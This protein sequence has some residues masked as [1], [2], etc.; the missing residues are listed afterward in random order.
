[1][2]WDDGQVVC[3]DDWCQRLDDSDGSYTGKLCLVRWFGPGWP[4][5]WPGRGVWRRDKLTLCLLLSA[6]PKS[7]GAGRVDC[8]SCFF[9]NPFSGGTRGP[10]VD[11]S[12]GGGDGDDDVKLVFGLLQN[13]V[14]Y[15][16]NRFC[17]PAGEAGNPR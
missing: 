6:P 1:M 12:S 14:K 15:Y 7:I 5:H 3:L 4:T 2:R 17:C 16:K 11:L 9:F 8:C 10:L 13:M